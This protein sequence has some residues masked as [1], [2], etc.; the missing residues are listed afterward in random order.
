MKKIKRMAYRYWSK[1]TDKGYKRKGYNWHKSIREYKRTGI[2]NTVDRGSGHAAGYDWAKRKA[3]DPDSK[4]RR[5]SKNSPSFD[6]GVY[7]YKQE[8]KAKSKMRDM[9]KNIKTLS[10][11]KKTSSP[12][13]KTEAKA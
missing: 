2:F 11:D 1:P 12:P 8:E 4:E 3:I 6:E 10:Y 5:Y 9:V 7:K 13:K